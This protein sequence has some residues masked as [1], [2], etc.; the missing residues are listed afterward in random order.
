MSGTKSPQG[1]ISRRSFLKTTGAVVGAAGLAGASTAL[2][3][4]AEVEGTQAN[5]DTTV[6]SGSCRGNCFQGCHIYYK[7]R[8]GRVV[9]TEAGKFPDGQYDRICPKGHSLPHRFYD[10]HRTQY[11]LRRVEGTERG[12]GQWERISW[13]EALSDIAEKWKGYLDELGGRSLGFVSISGNSGIANGTVYTRLMNV[14]GATKLALHVDNALFKGTIDTL[15]R[16]V[17]WNSN[18]M[19]DMIN[20]RCLFVWGSNTTESQI[21][22]WHFMAE[23]IDAG[24]KMLEPRMVASGQTL[25]A[26]LSGEGRVLI[27]KLEELR[28]LPDGGKGVRLMD[29]NAGEELLM[30]VPID[31]RGVEVSGMRGS[32][33]RAKTLVRADFERLMAKRARKGREPEVRFVVNAV[34]ALAPAESGSEQSA[35]EKSAAH[36]DEPELL[37]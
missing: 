2:P 15:G 25:L 34:A 23:A 22:M 26:C 9:E 16:A 7:V 13:D 27:F 1:G 32:T 8:E 21:Q 36:D 4:L 31:Q 19:S 24:A 17:A 35:A 33:A 18:D 10:E 29:L 14:L 3:A 12:A 6:Y 28:K 37:V 11:P 30:A 20:T 5:D